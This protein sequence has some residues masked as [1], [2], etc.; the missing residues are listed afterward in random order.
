MK[1]TSALEEFLQICEQD[2]MDGSGHSIEVLSTS[3]MNG[4][5]EIDTSSSVD[6]LQTEAV[7]CSEGRSHSGSTVSGMACLKRSDDERVVGDWT[8]RM[9]PTVDRQTINGASVT[10]NVVEETPPEEYNAPAAHSTPNP[11][12]DDIG[13]WINPDEMPDHLKAATIRVARKYLMK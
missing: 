8:R 10:E 1:S 2:H 7:P 5:L 3:E 6:V 4:S 9:K 11:C 13:F 12:D